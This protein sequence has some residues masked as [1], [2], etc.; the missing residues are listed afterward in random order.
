MQVLGEIIQMAR[1]GH[2]L[3][4]GSLLG[5]ELFDWLGILRLNLVQEDPQG[6]QGIEQRDNQLYRL[7]RPEADREV[8]PPSRIHGQGVNDTV[9][10]LL[11]DGQSAHASLEL[12]H[13]LS[14]PCLGLGNLVSRVGLLGNVWSIKGWLGGRFGRLRCCLCSWLGIQMASVPEDSQLDSLG[15]LLGQQRLEIPVK[16]LGQGKQGRAALL[17]DQPVPA[18][19]DIDGEA[20]GD[21]LVLDLKVGWLSWVCRRDVE[22]ALQMC[23]VKR[24][25]GIRGG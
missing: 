20:T 6:L 7:D 15:L 9:A 23:E 8:G 16:S 3:L 1:Q 4:L 24:K 14:A 2:L 19:F 18:I 13:F 21:I 11:V 22:L 10:G 12:P 5:K 17:L 25:V